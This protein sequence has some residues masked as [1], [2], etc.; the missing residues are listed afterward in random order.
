M[1]Q[2]KKQ[3]KDGPISDPFANYKKPDAAK[4][5]SNFV[6]NISKNPLL[7][8][9]PPFTTKEQQINGNTN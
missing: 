4:Q 1:Q 9:Y 6:D 8:K 2:A 5:T 3:R 7:N